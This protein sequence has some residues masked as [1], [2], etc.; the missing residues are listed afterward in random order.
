MA[1]EGIPV[2]RKEGTAIANMYGA[3]P[4]DQVGED[5]HCTLH[6]LNFSALRGGSL[7]LI[8]FEE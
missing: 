3:Y 7:I 4:A 6:L 8:L 2:E 5:Q 1:A